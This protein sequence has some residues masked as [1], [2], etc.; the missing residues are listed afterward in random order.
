MILRLLAVIATK[1]RHIL[2]LYLHGARPIF[3][4]RMST[5]IQP[6]RWSYE[7]KLAV[8]IFA[9]PFAMLLSAC[10]GGSVQPGATPALPPTFVATTSD[11]SRRG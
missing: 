2:G 7:R 9:I 4:P 5:H 8:L 10:A 3:K 1:P 6:R 11:T